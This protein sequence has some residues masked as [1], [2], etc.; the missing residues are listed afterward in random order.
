V[1]YGWTG[2]FLRIDLTNGTAVKEPLNMEWARAY[3]GG[4]GL[5]TR[6]LYEEIDP[7]CD[8]L[9]PENRLFSRPAH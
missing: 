1:P 2:Q 8:P 6:Y 9:G 5:G 7:M 3:I 4:R